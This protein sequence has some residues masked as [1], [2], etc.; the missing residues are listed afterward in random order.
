[1]TKP[2]A[3]TKQ[4]TPAKPMRP[5]ASTSAS[6]SVSASASAFALAVACACVCAFTWAVLLVAGTLAAQQAATS[7]AQPPHYLF[8]SFRGNG[9]DG[10][11][12]AHSRDGLRW[13]A[14]NGD[15]SFLRPTVGTRLMRDPSIVRGPD[16]MFHLVWT[17]GWW[18]RGIGVAHSK[19]LITWSAQEAIPVMAHEP[20]AVNCW[21]PDAFYDAATGEFVIV[22]STTIPGR[23]PKTEES[24]DEGNQRKLNHR[25]YYVTTRD[26][27]TYSETK[28]FYDGGFNVIDGTIV[29]ADAGTSPGADTSAGAGANAGASAPAPAGAGPAGYVLIVKDETKRPVAKKHLRTVVGPRAIGPWGQASAAITSDWVEGPA[30]LKVG[31]AWIVYFDEYTRKRYGAI[32]STDLKTWTDISS[33]IDLPPGTRHGS[34]FAVPEEIAAALLKPEGGGASAAPAGTR[35]FAGSIEHPA[36]DYAGRPATDAVA[37]LDQQIGAGAVQLRFEKDTGYLRALLEILR[38]TK[39]GL[40][41]LPN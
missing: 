33:Q 25:M 27:K 7:G 16:G 40:P 23:F 36:I 24:G 31:D 19:D 34:A 38:D 29:K 22:W 37:L 41:E 21:A 5:S 39:K 26:F 4:M 35:R 11:H 3:L 1:M 2:M 18:D 13:T 6:V 12:L 9:E 20:T 32:R 14:L 15:R 30:A 28:L 10:L 17:T 8:A